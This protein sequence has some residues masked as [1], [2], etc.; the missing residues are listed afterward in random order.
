[1]NEKPSDQKLLALSVVII[2]LNEELNIKRALASVAWADEIIVY[3]S[4]SRDQTV[5]IAEK[6]GAKVI[7]GPWLGFGPTKKKAVEEAR[8]D[9]ILSID[10]DEEVPE[11]L[12]QEI[13][14]K[15]L[16]FDV[17]TA[18]QIPRLSNYLGKWIHYGGW[19]PDRQVRLFN[20]KFANW[21]QAEIH[22]KVVATQYASLTSPF[23]HYV[24]RDIEHQVQTNNR[25]STLLAAEMFKQKKSFS[26]FHYLTKPSVKFVEC[27]FLKRGLM[28]GWVGFLI[29]RNAAYSVFLKWS[30]LKELYLRES[31]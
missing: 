21:D 25:Y 16:S 19:Y 22:E 12:A 14:E 26:W 9:W 24:F 18:Y 29:S 6:L 11:A 4:G 7:R 3:D 13:H 5:E 8:H 30:K 2:A 28:D 20:R 17:H 27:Y 23:H 15:R 10:A 1:M 31:P